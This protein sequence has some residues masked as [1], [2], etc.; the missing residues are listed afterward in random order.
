MVYRKR[1]SIDTITKKF[2]EVEMIHQTLEDKLN[3]K[4]PFNKVFYNTIDK[5]DQKEVVNDKIFILKDN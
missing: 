2:Y 3:N 1:T 4:A 5:L